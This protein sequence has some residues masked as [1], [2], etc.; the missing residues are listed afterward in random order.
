MQGNKK[1][2]RIDKFFKAKYRC[3]LVVKLKVIK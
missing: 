1:S 2:K 3:L